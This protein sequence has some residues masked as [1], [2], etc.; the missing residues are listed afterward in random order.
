MF[1]LKDYGKEEY[2]DGVMSRYE[3]QD[4]SN[5]DV[6]A[7]VFSKKMGEKIVRLINGEE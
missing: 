6:I 5:D 2:L 7:H 1:T 3:I 4:N